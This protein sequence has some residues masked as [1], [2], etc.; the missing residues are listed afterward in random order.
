M[1]VCESK[2][3][4]NTWTDYSQFSEKF[5]IGLYQT[6][7]KRDVKLR[8]PFPNYLSPLK[9]CKGALACKEYKEKNIA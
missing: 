6:G 3:L 7:I 4:V 5:F 8:P 1:F 9:S 2:D